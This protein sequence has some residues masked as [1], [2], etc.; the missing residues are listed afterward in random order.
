MI[1]IRMFIRKTNKTLS[2]ASNTDLLVFSS[3]LI[4]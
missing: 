2:S 1:L 3:I 4:Y